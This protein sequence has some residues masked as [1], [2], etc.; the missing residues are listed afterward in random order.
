[1]SIRFGK[2][3]CLKET[4]DVAERIGEL[5]MLNRLHEKTNASEAYSI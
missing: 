5:R 4:L 1:M 2:A 3:R